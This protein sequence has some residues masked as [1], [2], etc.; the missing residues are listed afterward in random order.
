MVVGEEV[1]R[2]NAELEASI[3][4]M[5]KKWGKMVSE[6]CHLELTKDTQVIFV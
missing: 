2:I 3:E 4:G 1:T 5:H 6:T